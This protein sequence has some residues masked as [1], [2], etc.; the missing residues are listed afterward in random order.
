MR[1]Q[2]LP[3]DIDNIK[4]EMQIHITLSGTKSQ[5][6]NKTGNLSKAVKS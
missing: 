3:I 6:F 2:H 1:Y 4:K 5:E